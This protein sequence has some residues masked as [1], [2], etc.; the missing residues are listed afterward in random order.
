MSEK[1]KKPQIWAHCKAG[2]EWETVHKDDLNEVLTFVPVY[3]DRASGGVTLKKGKTYKIFNKSTDAY[4]FK[5]NIKLRKN[6]IITL[7]NPTYNP[8]EN[9]ILFKLVD[10]YL[11]E[12]KKT[13]VLYEINGESYREE[14]GDGIIPTTRL[15]VYFNSDNGG[16]AGDGVSFFRYEYGEVASGETAEKKVIVDVEYVDGEYKEKLYGDREYLESY[17]K[18]GHT[19]ITYNSWDGNEETITVT[20]YIKDLVWKSEF[21]SSDGITYTYMSEAEE[22]YFSKNSAPQATLYKKGYIAKYA[23]DT[24]YEVTEH[25]WQEEL[26]DSGKVLLFE[27]VNGNTYTAYY[28]DPNQEI[29]TNNVEAYLLDFDYVVEYNADVTLTA[30]TVF[31]KYADDASG[32]NMSAEY[33]GQ[34]Y[35]GVYKG[36]KE[37]ENA[38]DYTWMAIS[39]SGL[40]I[41]DIEELNTIPSEYQDAEKLKNCLL[42]DEAFIYH[43]SFFDDSDFYFENIDEGTYRYI[44]I[45]S[46]DWAIERQGKKQLATK[47]YVDNAVAGAGVIIFTPIREE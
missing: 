11:D 2:C 38:S 40:K 1:F 18:I 29:D 6:L 7:N 23:L 47:E 41:I 44:Y 16:V 27:T 31:I 15:V 33:S 5:I 25:T 17:G 37:S 42:R 20:P 14:L 3:P 22:T 24:H 43:L 30:E 21:T 45:A 39:G 34:A 28:Y 32:T 8:Y 26:S 9:Y 12:S 4:T 13:I 10:I 35:L 36:K 46:N 19:K